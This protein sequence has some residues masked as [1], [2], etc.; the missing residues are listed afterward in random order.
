MKHRYRVVAKRVGFEWS[1]F[2]AQHSPDGLGFY[3]IN[4]NPRLDFNQAKE[5]MLKF[6]QAQSLDIGNDIKVMETIK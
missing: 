3:S 1:E 5:D 2:Y 4:P 6:K